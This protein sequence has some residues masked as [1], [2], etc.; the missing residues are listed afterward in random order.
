M[1]IQNLYRK[2]FQRGRDDKRNNSLFWRK[3]NNTAFINKN[4][5]RSTSPNMF[6]DLTYIDSTEVDENIYNYDQLKKEYEEQIREDIN[7]NKTL[8]FTDD[9]KLEEQPKEILQKLVDF[10]NCTEAIRKFNIKPI[11]CLVYNYEQQKHKPIV[12]KMSRKIWL[13]IKIWLLI[14]ICLAI[15]CWC[16]KGK[17]YY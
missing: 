7:S 12:K 16:H 4:K 11:N 15:P 1:K 17:E 10:K 5:R 2:S 6:E 14:Y 3:I 9:K 8:N 13:T